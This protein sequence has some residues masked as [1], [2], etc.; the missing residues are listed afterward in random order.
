MV[1]TNAFDSTVVEESR[2]KQ[3]EFDSSEYKNM[4]PTCDVIRPKSI[5][6]VLVSTILHCTIDSVN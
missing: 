5:Q 3:A 2:N 4:H 1:V 6:S